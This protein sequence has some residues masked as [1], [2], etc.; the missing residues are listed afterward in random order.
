MAAWHRTGTRHLRLKSIIS[1]KVWIVRSKSRYLTKR[2]TLVMTLSDN[3]NWHLIYFVSKK[4]SMP[5]YRFAGRVSHRVTSESKANG[6]LVNLKSWS[7]WAPNCDKWSKNKDFK[8]KRKF[9]RRQRR[10][11]KMLLLIKKLMKRKLQRSWRRERWAMSRSQFLQSQTWS[12]KGI[13][14]CLLT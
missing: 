11:P 3:L 1:I 8:S 6:T 13:I 2:H 4:V 10:R 14:P 5:G 9:K 7:R 12:T